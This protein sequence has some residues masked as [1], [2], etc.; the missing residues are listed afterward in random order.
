MNTAETIQVLNSYNINPNK[1]YGQNFLCNKAIIDR[2]IDVSAVS[3]QDKVL[4]IGPGLGGLTEK[5][6]VKS[7]SV[8]AV[9]IDSGLAG[10]LKER[11]SGRKN[12]IIIHADFLKSDLKQNF[13]KSVSNLPYYCSSEILFHLAVKYKIPELY[14]MLQKEMSER[15]ISGPGSKNFGAMT[16]ALGLYYEPRILFHINRKSFYPSPDVSSSFLQLK[17]RD[18]GLTQKERELFHLIVKSA[19][20]GRRKTLI[21]ALTES[22]HL[23]LNRELLINTFNDLNYDIKLRGENLDIKDFKMLTKKIADNR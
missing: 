8:T 10:F 3:T 16:V 14:V 4:E 5:L 11:F 9:E 7:E 17:Q 23:K 21:K 6:A 15:I 20:W 1:A 22:P 18:T 12:I 2:I 19:F 13:T